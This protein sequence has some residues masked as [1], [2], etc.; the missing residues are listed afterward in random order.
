MIAIVF[1][2]VQVLGFVI[3]LIGGVL[4]FGLYRVFT[5]T[6]TE[7]AT[8]AQMVIP[9]VHVG[10]G[11]G[12]MSGKDAGRQVSVYLAV[13]YVTLGTLVA[14]GV[15]KAVDYL[16]L[17]PVIEFLPAPVLQWDAGL[18]SILCFFVFPIFL[19]LF[20][21]LRIVA[22][23]YDATLKGELSWH[24]PFPVI[25]TGAFI[26]AFSLLSLSQLSFF[27]RPEGRTIFGLELT[28][29]HGQAAR[30]AEFFIPFLISLW[31]L[32]GRGLSWLFAFI[33][34]IYFCWAP[35]AVKG[36]EAFHL[37]DTQFSIYAVG[38]VFVLLSLLFYWEFFWNVEEWNQR[39]RAG[40]EKG[41]RTFLFWLSFFVAAG[42]VG[43]PRLFQLRLN[44]AGA[45]KPASSGPVVVE[46]VPEA[47]GP[48]LHLE[49]TSIDS[50][51]AYAV[52][53][54]NLVKIGDHV[55]GYQVEDIQRN[56]VLLSK[57]NVL[58]ELDLSGKLKERKS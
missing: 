12:L 40:K 6:P 37:M 45:P 8:V 13:F 48:K 56:L 43:A 23:R 49:G 16:P 31:L 46:E 42:I 1:F 44:F 53:E 58:Y 25:L 2:F 20:L 15:A 27:T 17:V 3:L 24:A 33:L 38:W 30:C 39:V 22:F 41:V 14:A 57:D 5:L 29:A 26:F 35:L 19:I 55:A 7:L 34:G 4:S 54:S 11:Y 36:S 32:M 50:H 10:A 18:V 28:P 21:N 52:I 47:A 51:G 9:L